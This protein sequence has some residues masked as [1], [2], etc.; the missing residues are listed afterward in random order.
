MSALAEGTTLLGRYELRSRVAAGGMGEV[1]RGHD[2]RLNRLVAVKVLPQRLAGQETFLQRL[3]IEARN[4]AQLRHPHVVTLLDYGEDAGAGVLVMEFVDGE[5]LGDVIAREGRLPAAEALAILAQAARGLHAAHAAGVIHRDV[6]P[7]NLLVTGS[8]FVKLT[9]FGIS[10]HRDQPEL[11]AAGMVMGTAHYLAPELALGRGAS[12]ATD[13]YS[14]GIIAFELLS[15]RRPFTGDSAVDVAYAHVHEPLPELPAD[16]PAPVARIVAS[17]LDKDPARR[18]RSGAA[19]ARSLENLI[20]A[21]S[22][23]APGQP[24]DRPR[25]AWRLPT[26]AELRADR[27]W[28]TAVSV[29]LAGVVLL[30]T[31]LLGSLAWAS[32]DDAPDEP[33]VHVAQRLESIARDDWW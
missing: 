21:G 25:G 22:S 5:P 26:L 11:T 13:L 6:K 31:L 1:W 29:G 12:P 33:R 32:S 7:S 23:A 18:P 8:G 20:P 9:D 10:R 19:L 14:L 2:A 24:A 15:G 16:I 4:N 27:V 30:G 17:L 3:R 28:L